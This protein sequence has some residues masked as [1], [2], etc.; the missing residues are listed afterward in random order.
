MFSHIF[1]F[2][3]SLYKLLLY[4]Q[5]EMPTKGLILNVNVVGLT[6]NGKVNGV[7][8]SCFCN[9]AVRPRQDDY[10]ENHSSISEHDRLLWANH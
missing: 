4:I 6:G 7:G 1:A 2:K 10:H 9:R 5:V 8:K 3:L